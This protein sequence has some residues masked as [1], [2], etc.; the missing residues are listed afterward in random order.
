M[1]ERGEESSDL[2]I[3]EDKSTEARRDFG[4]RPDVRPSNVG[5]GCVVSICLLVTSLSVAIIKIFQL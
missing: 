4:R 2:I 1:A 3:R 5:I